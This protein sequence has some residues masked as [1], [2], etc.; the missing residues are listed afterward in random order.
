MCRGTNLSSEL[1]RAV[2]AVRSTQTAAWKARMIGDSPGALL[3]YRRLQLSFPF[4]KPLA[5]VKGKT[6]IG[7]A[8]WAA[9]CVLV[10]LLPHATGGMGGMGLELLHSHAYHVEE[11]LP[12]GP[13]C[14]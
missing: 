3:G 7:T 8:S 1:T 6:T 2:S 9:E 10:S 4:N 12:G 13:A 5:P 14:C 11:T